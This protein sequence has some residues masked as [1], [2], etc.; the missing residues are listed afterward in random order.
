MSSIDV[1]AY[2]IRASSER[3]IEWDQLR[4]AIKPREIRTVY[5]YE[6]SLHI[7]YLAR[8]KTNGQGEE[9]IDLIFVIR[10]DL[11]FA[12]RQRSRSIDQSAQ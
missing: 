8:E 4:H 10:S 2:S 1:E 3:S 12:F 11:S 5:C 7:D 6:S 9:S